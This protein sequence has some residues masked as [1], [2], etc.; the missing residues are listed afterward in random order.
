[1]ANYGNTIIKKR[2]LIENQLFVVLGSIYNDRFNVAF[3]I[4]SQ[5]N[6]IIEVDPPFSATTG[7]VF[8]YT[9]NYS[10]GHI[11]LLNDYSYYELV[12]ARLAH[13]TRFIELI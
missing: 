6:L 9:I 7:L 8:I 3:H 13:S 4:L 2:V 12:A 5:K 10:Y 11:N 1:M